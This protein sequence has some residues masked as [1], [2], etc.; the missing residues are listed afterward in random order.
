VTKKGLGATK[1]GARGDSRRACTKTF[2][3][4]PQFTFFKQIILKLKPCVR[5]G[6][7]IPNHPK[8]PYAFNAF[9][10]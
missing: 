6:K 7:V 4:Q 10:L 9:I 2:L 3:A 1:K 8:N 5:F